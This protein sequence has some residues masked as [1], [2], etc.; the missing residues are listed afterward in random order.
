MSSTRWFGRSDSPEWVMD[1]EGRLLGYKDER[2]IVHN[3]P[4][5]VA[6]PITDESEIRT[7]ITA[8]PD[9]S[10][11]PA[12]AGAVLRA[13]GGSDVFAGG[14]SGGDD[15]ALVQEQINDLHATYGRRGAVIKVPDKAW[16][17]LSGI[18]LQPGITFVS[19]QMYAPFTEGTSE[20]AG[21]RFQLPTNCSEP[22]FQNAI[23]V[24]PDVYPRGDGSGSEDGL[25]QVYA[26]NG[27]FGINFNGSLDVTAHTTDADLIRLLRA[28]NTQ[29]YGCTFGVA[30]GF[31]VRS[32]DCNVLRVINNQCFNVSMFFESL[33]DSRVMDND[34]FN[35]GSS[36]ASAIWITGSN[37]HKNII[38]GNL[39]GNNQSNGYVT[40]PRRQFAPDLPV[41]AVNTTTG[42]ITLGEYAQFSG[43]GLGHL[44][45]DGT[46]VV[47]IVRRTWNSS[48]G[49]PTKSGVVPA[50]FIE[51]A[52]YWVKATATNKIKL[53]RTRKDL[54]DGVYVIPSD[55]GSGSIWIN[56][57]KQAAVYVNDG[58]NGNNFES[59]RIDQAYGA[60]IMFDGATNNTMA[61]APMIQEGSM[62]NYIG[63]TTE[64]PYVYESPVEQPAVQLINGSTG[65]KVHGNIDGTKIG[66]LNTS[67]RESRQKW[68]VFIDA[69][70]EDSSWV[71]SGTNIFN[72]N[73][74]TSSAGAADYY[75]DRYNPDTLYLSVADFYAVSGSTIPAVQLVGGSR[76]AA[77]RFSNGIDSVIGAQLLVPHGW[78]HLDIYVLWVNQGAGAGNVVW[79]ADINAF[80]VGSSANAA[81]TAT[82]DVSGAAGSQDV[83]CATL[84]SQLTWTGKT[85]KRARIRV[86]RVG[87][88]GS[89][90]L[91]NSAGLVGIKIVR[92]F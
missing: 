82:S 53:A 84:L 55:A 2:G 30:R 27:F 62:G 50:G 71:A 35:G 39:S 81:D 92:R 89:D 15:S 69:S 24:L 36:C 11:D 75:D 9:G 63:S 64:S 4:N 78:K 41:T 3:L 16:S 48:G 58:A 23:G 19:E 29:I 90:T 22:M 65:V 83:L 28:W 68:G 70:S 34:M 44:W 49:E 79:H 61:A 32:L 13:V 47:F 67:S 66:T 17:V 8:G 5:S 80:D 1:A 12:G 14:K 42:E 26:C 88:S 85:G 31:A 37:A 54:T 87:T 76:E 18:T 74:G 45:S 51:S 38:R 6:D 72:H 91:A 60:S 10:L 40:H 59:G 21:P 86:K 73:S 77:W 57:G 20:M 25:P 33:A 46:P 56:C 52:T 7:P 43:L